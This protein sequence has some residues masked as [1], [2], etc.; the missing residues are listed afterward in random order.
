MGYAHD[1]RRLPSRSGATDAEVA[2][3]L[4]GDDL[5]PDATDVVD[6]AAT[7][8]APPSEVW[9][10]LVQLG[11]KRAG[12]YF[13]RRVE[14]MLPRRGRGLRH[15]DPVWQA[16]APGEDIPDYGPGTPV[17]RATTVDPRRALVY[18]S[19]RDRAN[20]HRWPADGRADRPGVLALSWA[21]VLTDLDGRTRLH[22]RLR[23]RVKHS[24]LAA[25]GGLFDWL[26]IQG[27]IAGL[28]ERLAQ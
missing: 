26:T 2:A 13:P 21:L 23:L 14:A 9:P 18:L 6:R 15:I 11:K 8:D 24:W 16:L 22:I 12:W 5:V 10:W 1:L 19:L 7:L 28:R 25:A 4:P 3:G 27:L 20:G 17:F